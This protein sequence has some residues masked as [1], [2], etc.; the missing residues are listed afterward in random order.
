M[1]ASQAVAIVNPRDGTGKTTVAIHLA[2]AAHRNGRHI[3]LLDADPQGSA[4]DWHRRT[5][6][7]YDGPHIEQFSRDR[8]LAAATGQTDA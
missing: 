1:S 8:I 4:M 2:T 7:N 5:S 3:A 6:D